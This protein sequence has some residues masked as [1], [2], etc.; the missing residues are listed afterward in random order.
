SGGPRGDEF[1]TLGGTGSGDGVFVAASA[2]FVGGGD[3]RQ[4][5]VHVEQ[6]QDPSRRDRNDLS[7]GIGET[8]RVTKPNRFAACLDLPASRREDVHDPVTVR[9][10]GQ[11]EQVPVAVAKHVDWCAV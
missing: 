8:L 11:R 7:T 2:G 4:E 3:Q 1:L 10:V 6:P 5:V 9:P